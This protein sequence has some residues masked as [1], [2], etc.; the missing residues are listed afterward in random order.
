M[1]VY[2]TVYTWKAQGVK[3]VHTI[4][5]DHRL[6]SRIPQLGMNNK[7]CFLM[8]RETINITGVIQDLIH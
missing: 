4:I 3:H 6:T 2:W 5:H 8:N 7:I 1:Y